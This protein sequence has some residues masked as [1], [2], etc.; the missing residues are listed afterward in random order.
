M[1][2]LLKK[3]LIL[4]KFKG[5]FVWVRQRS[6]LRID[7]WAFFDMGLVID[8]IEL[9]KNLPKKTLNFIKIWNFILLKTF[10]FLI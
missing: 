2:F 9:T 1:D 3:T 4:L 7:L 5:I 10:I 8:F 6:L